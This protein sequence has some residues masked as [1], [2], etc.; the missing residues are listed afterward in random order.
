MGKHLNY[1]NITEN[2]NCYFIDDTQLTNFVLKPVEYNILLYLDDDGTVSQ[3]EHL[4]TMNVLR[5]KKT[6][7]ASKIVF[8]LK[9]DTRGTKVLNNNSSLLLFLLRFRKKSTDSTA[10]GDIRRRGETDPSGKL[11]IRKA[12]LFQ[13]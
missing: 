4:I 7:A 5:C 12:G 8:D 6:N 11:L 2:D 3:E 9:A 13:I 10:S 1:N